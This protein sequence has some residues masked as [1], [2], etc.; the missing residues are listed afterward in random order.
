[1][2]TDLEVGAK[3]EPSLDV[4]HFVQAEVRQFVFLSTL[5]RSQVGKILGVQQALNQQNETFVR[6]VGKPNPKSEMK[7][8]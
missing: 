7:Y 1:M 4:P 2:E 5:G 3:R 8:S 6:R